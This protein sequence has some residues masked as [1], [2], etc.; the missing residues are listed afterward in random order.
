VPVAG[1]D[2]SLASL[3]VV[4]VVRSRHPGE[5]VDLLGHANQLTL[6]EEASLA[7]GMELYIYIYIV[8]SGYVSIPNFFARTSSILSLTKLLDGAG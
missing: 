6:T 8:I 5:A 3:D 7:M 1:E 2:S 4:V